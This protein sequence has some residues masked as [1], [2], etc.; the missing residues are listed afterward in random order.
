VLHVIPSMGPLRGGPTQA[1]RALAR[2]QARLG[3]G[4]TIATTDD[5]GP[6]LL[7]LPLNVPISDSGVSTWYF[8]RQHRFYTVSR[9]L[10]SWV[11]ANVPCHDVVHIHALFSYPSVVAAREAARQAVPYVVRPLGTLNR[12]G[13]R[14]RRPALKR[15]SFA[16]IERRILCRAG[17]V[18]FTSGLEA[19]EAR[20]VW[21][22]RN[23]AVIPLGLPDDAFAP[24][25]DRSACLR[26]LRLAADAQVVLFLSR[27][28]P[29]KGLEVLISAFAEIAPRF[30]CAVLIVAGDGSP[31]YVARLR[32]LVTALGIGSRILFTG[33]LD[34][35][36]KRVA[37]GAADCFALPSRSENFGIAPVEAMAAGVPVIVSP[38]TGI[39]PDVARLSAGDVV[40]CDARA[41]A[42]AL[43]RLLSSPALR[44]AYAANGSKAAA[45]EFSMARTARQLCEL[46][47]TIAPQRCAA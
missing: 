23:G 6:G 46:Y 15:L 22:G 13:M 16:L 31:E 47:A 41:L 35:E 3:L 17:A 36:E 29:K 39:A 19:D 32:A 4:V 44:D 20:D 14:N 45:R 18:H 7:P 38:D 27:L 34:D 33:F 37:F 9:P 24:R 43:Y 2:E 21:A 10:A 40:P 8:R 12:W 1:L 11:R 26:R 5:N 28:D 42:S 25:M 30:D